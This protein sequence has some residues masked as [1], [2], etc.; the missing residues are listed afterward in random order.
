MNYQKALCLFITTGLSLFT[1]SAYAIESVVTETQPNNALQQRDLHDQQRA[2]LDLTAKMQALKMAMCA[3]PLTAVNADLC[4]PERS[5]VKN[6]TFTSYG[7]MTY[8][9]RPVFENI[10]DTQPVR[11]AK[12]D[13][14]RIVGEFKYFPAENWE[15][16]VE[17]EFEHGGVGAAMEY[18][19]FDEFGE[20]ETELE[21]GGEVIIEKAQI[22]YQ[23]SEAWGLKFGRIYLPVGIGSDFTKPTQYFTTKRHWG[24]ATMIPQ[25]WDETGVNVF[26]R[27]QGFQYQAVLSTGL[28]SEFFRTGSWVAGGH[29]NRFESVNAD[30]LALT[31]RLDYGNVKANQ[32][33][34]ISYYTGNTSDNRNNQGKINQS[35]NVQIVGLHGAYEFSSMII[36][37]QF[38]Q[39][40][41]SDTQA[42]TNANK[43][44]P[45]LNAG[46]LTQVG[47]EAQSWFVEAGVN[48]SS[49][50]PIS[51]P[52]YLFSSVEFA[53]PIHAV[54]SGTASERYRIQEHSIGVNY[55]PIEQIILKAQLAN[56]QVKQ[57][58]IPDTTAF[59]MAVGYYFS[60]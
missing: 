3:L 53:N 17:V 44:T 9:N 33:F 32:G 8:D 58:N 56:I 22:E 51:A 36:R 16:E 5:Q 30:A 23:A 14:E 1:L 26:G 7:S 25:V 19:G 45:G 37:G 57:T 39:G 59:T 2:L 13:L 15:I 48:L 10:Q 34:G 31:L 42:I 41:L 4:A 28:N 24:E 47:S 20:F 6:W 38:L 21:A 55:L 52:L 46:S 29:Q 60:L 43:T 49:H 35:G 50:L 18:D 40:Q 54:A 12:A 11:R 27:V